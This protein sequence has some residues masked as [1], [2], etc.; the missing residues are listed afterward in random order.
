MTVEEGIAMI[1]TLLGQAALNDLQTTI[2]RLSWERK[3]YPEIAECAGYDADYVKL[4]GFQLWK[5]LSNVLGERITKNNFHSALLRWST[6]QPIHFIDLQPI[7]PSK[8]NLG[9]T[10]RDWGEAVDV[11]IFYGRN[12]ELSTLEHWIV[13]D[14]CRLLAIL[15]I[16]GTGKTALS[17]KLAE[18]I[19]HR[20]DVVI[21]RSLYNAPT[22]QSFFNDLIGCLAE[23]T[24]DLPQ[25]IHQSISKLFEY[26]RQYRCLLVLDNAETILTES[27]S[28]QSNGRTGQYRDGLEAYGE[29]FRKIGEIKHQSCLIVTSREKPKEIAVL[30]GERLPVRSFLLTGLSTE[31]GKLIFQ[32]KGEFNGSYQ[33]WQ[34][35]INSYA[36]NPLALKIVATTIRDLFNSNIDSFLS[37]NSIVFGDIQ[38]LLDQQFNRLSG[39]EKELLYW[40]A[41]NREPV[42]ITDLKSDLVIQVPSNRFVEALESLERRSLIEKLTST[43]PDIKTPV[44][45]LQPV[46]ME[47]L[48]HQFIQKICQELETHAIRLYKSHALIKAQTK[49]YI[50]DI[51]IRLILAPVVQHL[52]CQCGNAEVI[53]VQL[54]Q[55]LNALR[56]KSSIEVGYAG[57]NTLNLLR[58]LQADLSGY[59]F[60]NLTL[61]QADLKNSI[62]HQTNF[63][64]S[65][66]SKT[67]FTESFSH[68]YSMAISPDKARLAT[69]DAQGQIYV[70]QLSNGQLLMSWNAHIGAVRSI[71]FTPDGQ[72]VVSGG[73][74]QLLKLWDIK[75]G[76]CCRMF[77]NRDGAIWS[78]AVS[79]DGETIAITDG[80][81]KLWHLPTSEYFSLVDH[82]DWATTV[83][84]SP[85]GQILAAGYNDGTIKLWDFH[86][87]V[88]L[89]TLSA[90]Q[91][92]SLI[93]LSFSPN[94][95]TLIS[96]SIDNQV[97]WWNL[98]TGG[99]VRSQV[100]KSWVWWVD[101]SPNKEMVV[102][103]SADQTIR[104]WDFHTG[105]L[106]KTLHGHEYGV[107]IVLFGVNSTL[108][109][110]DEGQTMKLWDIPTGQCLKTWRGYGGNIWAIAFSPDGRTLISSGE[111][112]TAKL[113][114]VR[115]EQCLK[116]L[117]GHSGWVRSVD[118]SPD[119]Q[120]VV[121]C[122]V[123]CM[124]KIWRVSTGKC[125]RTIQGHTSFVWSVKYSPDGRAI[126]TCSVDYTVRLWD[127]HTGV[128]LNILNHGSPVVAVIYSP[129]GHVLASYGVNRSIKLWDVSTGDCLQSLQ[130]YDE[131]HFSTTFACGDAIAFSPDGQTLASNLDTGSIQLWN[132]ATGQPLRQFQAHDS[133]VVAIVYSPD[134][135]QL[136]SAGL[137]QA[138]KVWDVK[139]GDCHRV[140]QSHVQ[141]SYS[142]TITRFPTEDSSINQFV[143]AS[144][145]N[146]RSVHFWNIETGEC[147][148]ILRNQR[149]YEG[150]NIT[151]IKGL[152]A[153]QYSTLKALGAIENGSPL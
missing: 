67:V 59:D 98:Q 22:P 142:L 130:I 123:D 21:W 84:F 77:H 121:T 82:L 57:G 117:K 26:L 119:N 31:D 55:I 65:D 12:K 120:T 52:L 30:E 49:D 45:A 145:G 129:D 126:A 94:G 97:K 56:N 89:K 115:T 118:F 128:C 90:H 9:R 16:G 104:L 78:I 86:T 100:H 29:F 51:Q 19:E 25:N 73:D 131:C 105:Q 87:R 61:W 36:G 122:G 108:I 148:K 102:S 28:S 85:D 11:S 5:S 14:Q 134:G 41:I 7:S 33:G 27:D 79:L 74:D 112:Q 109:S 113:W 47:Y 116:L 72:T 152:T 13:Q 20:F 153:T 44:F 70:W 62:L 35:L 4:V 83:R 124:I 95:Q 127:V 136:V 1:E 58:Q 88:C 2:L 48:T 60:S 64:G 53:S 137:D 138:I 146:D 140:L 3:T 23:K 96:G 76:C 150:M 66:L 144:S 91:T 139:T 135:K 24:T 63:S 40:L 8:V 107:R 54:K 43:L 68:V 81:I 111:E 69:A 101:C 18:Y 132:M 106:I 147:L 38:D 99:C 75:T 17:I 92:R 103:C 15:G 151:D 42:T 50:Q 34:T 10:Y 6:A 80:T 37:Q 149:P 133:P 141:W 114:D 125:L 32:A 46:L 110:S 143:L 93:C 39:L 71:T